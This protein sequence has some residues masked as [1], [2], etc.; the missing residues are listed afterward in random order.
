MELQGQG[1]DPS[2]SCS[3]G[4][5]THCARLGIRP[6]SQHSQDATDPAATQ[7]DLPKQVF[8]AL[9]TEDGGC[10]G[11]E[12]GEASPTD[13]RPARDSELGLDRPTLK[14]HSRVSDGVREAGEQ[15]AGVAHLH[16]RLPPL[17]REPRAH[18]PWSAST[19]SA[20]TCLTHV[21]RFSKGFQG[22]Q[23]KQD[24]RRD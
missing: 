4:S 20:L 24:Q 22:H 9:M 23:H 2:Q 5:L 17:G 3:T 18:L 21:H 15:Q 14:M 16:G 19:L 10:S 8:Q 11:G 1:A 12:W 6:E 7:W 13:M